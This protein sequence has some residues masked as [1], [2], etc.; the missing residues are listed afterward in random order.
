MP[1][2]NKSF[3]P[4][5]ESLYCFLSE[6]LSMRNLILI[7]LIFLLAI[8]SHAQQPPKP[9]LVVGI[10]VDQMRQEYL[11]RFAN[12]YSSGGFKRL[13]NDG[14][15]LRNAHYNYVPTFTGPGHA[16]VYTGSTPAVHGIIG[17]DWYDKT[18]KKEVNC[19]NDPT[20]KPVGSP[21]G[22]GDVS[23]WRLLSSTITDE[24]RLFSQKRSKVVSVS[25]KDRGA[26]LPGGH[27]P[28]GAYWFDT[29]TGN[30]ITST[31]Y[32]SKLPDWVSKFNQLKLAEKYLNQEWK[33]F[34]P[35][36]EYTESGPDDSPYETKFEG[37]D[38]TTFPYD[39][40]EIRKKY[41]NYE[42]LYEVPFADDYLTDIAKAALSGEQLGS[43]DWTDFLAV[44]Y[45]TP[46][47]I[48]HAMGPNS[49]EIED[50]YV[51][52]DRNIEDLLK[53]LD[54]KVGA[55]NYTVFLT[56]DH[57]VADVAQYLTD[58]KIPSGYFSPA[59]TKAT[60]NEF[61]QK[62]F[63]GKDVI[64]SIDD[65]QIFFNHD[66]FQ[67]DPKSSGVELMVATELVVNYLLA[68]PGIANAFSESVIRQSR[69]D[70]AGIKGMVVRGYHPKRSADVVMVLEPGWYSASKVPGTTHGSPYPYDTN[71]PIIFYG[72]GI[73]KGSSVRYH[74]I[75]DIAPTLSM[76]LNIKIPNGCTGQPIAELFE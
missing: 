7:P 5:S 50:T 16:S 13:M 30:F 56:A 40:K 65:N 71:V 2:T 41:P 36:S 55:N 57:A 64:E 51:R 43:D 69:Y 49:I 29:Q 8:P 72:H 9:K 4:F 63:P 21:E 73:K 70:E 66:I 1:F 12:K 38:K 35:I 15:V 39:L 22:N 67:R 60:L 10:V 54:E 31:Y 17:N 74:S 3:Q 27:M 44:S 32:M 11:Y 75:T 24:L 46:D 14:F 45:S 23:P 62:Y 20:Q 42:L 19:V 34:L 37:K 47:V 58:N 53:T 61:L 18:L 76:L 25:F 68:Q 28:N 26:V 6:S 48:G 59:K 52:L 33:T